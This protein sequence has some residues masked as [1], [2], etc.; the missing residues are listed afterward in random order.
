MS[1]SAKKAL[2]KGNGG[3]L[4]FHDVEAFDDNEIATIEETIKQHENAYAVY[5]QE[6][7]DVGM[8][9]LMIQ[10]LDKEIK[11]LQ[12]KL[13]E[14]PEFKAL[15]EKKKQRK[16]FMSKMHDSLKRAE[17]AVLTVLQGVRKNT[18]RFDLLKTWHNTLQLRS[19]KGE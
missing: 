3:K 1:V 19:G 7:S 10:N 12:A 15:A 5:Q 14:T 4:I 8:A 18:R 13:R 2:V 11:G 9:Q 16:A 6:A 17:G